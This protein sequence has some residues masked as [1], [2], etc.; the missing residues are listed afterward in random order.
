MGRPIKL[1]SKLQKQIV[2]HLS[3]GVTI[4]DTC[5]AVGIAASTYYEWVKRGEEGDIEFSEFSEAVSRAHNAAKVKAIETIHAA[6]LPFTQKSVSTKTYTE[7]RLNKAG[8]PYEYKEVSKTETNTRM[9]GDWRA[10]ESLL[11]RRFPDEWSERHEVTGKG[12]KPIEIDVETLTNEQLARIIA[13]AAG[14]TG[15][16]AT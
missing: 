13:G 12:G 15:D 16:I 7:T 14:G 4:E 6:M 8:E 1:D 10:A 9:Q 5:S 3:N 11:K 2:K